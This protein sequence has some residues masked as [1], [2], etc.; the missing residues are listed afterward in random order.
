MGRSIL[1]IAIMIV[2]P[3]LSGCQAQS[4]VCPV[5][6]AHLTDTELVEALGATPTAFGDP[7]QVE[8]GGRKLR[9]D[10]VVSGALCNDV[11]H[12]TVYVTCGARVAAWQENPTFLQNCNLQIEPATVVYVAAHNDTAYYQGC[13]CH[14][15]EVSAP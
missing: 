3:W 6:S 2:L 9:V 7:A 13:S 8:I 4:T 10:K 5:P 15:G 12:G 11:W 1:P 14:T